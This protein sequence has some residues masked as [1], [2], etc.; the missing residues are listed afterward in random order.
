MS[1]DE[2]DLADRSVQAAVSTSGLLQEGDVAASGHE[3]ARVLSPDAPF[4]LA[5]FDDMAL[6]T[7]MSTIARTLARH[8]LPETLPDFG[9]LTRLAAPGLREQV[10][11]ESGLEQLHA[12]LFH[13]AIPLPSFDLVWQIASAPVPFARAF[14]A[15]DSVGTN[16]LKERVGR[17]E[18]FLD[19]LRRVADGGTA[20]DPEV[21]A[22]LLPRK[23]GAGSPA[24]RCSCCP[25]T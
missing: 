19:A 15:L 4:S 20:I 22:Q 25:R 14:A 24:S 3:L 12:E 8:V 7:L 18:E 21:V 6:N 2:L 13:W 11:R 16:L 17:V 5:A 10:L 1:V 23:P 9:Y